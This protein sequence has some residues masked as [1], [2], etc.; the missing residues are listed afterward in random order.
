MCLIDPGKYR[1]VDEVVSKE[2]RGQG[3]M[4]LLDLKSFREGEELME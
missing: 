3:T 2:T 4:E 1:E